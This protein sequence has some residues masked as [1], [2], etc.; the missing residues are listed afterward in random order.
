M[1]VYPYQP[2][3]IVGQTF[4]LCVQPNK[5]F[6]IKI[7]YQGQEEALT[8]ISEDS[9]KILSIDGVIK[10][11]RGKNGRAIYVS[12]NRVSEQ[13]FDT[14]WQWPSITFLTNRDV[15]QTNAY[16]AVVFE[17][18]NDGVG[19]DTLGQK[20]DRGEAILPYPPDSD[21]MALLVGKPYNPATTNI[22][23]IIPTATYQVYNWTGGG[24]FYENKYE[25]A[26]GKTVVTTR[27][28]GG[29]LGTS[30]TNLGE[31]DDAY[32]KRS[33]RQ[34]FV[35]WDAKFIRWMKSENITC[36]F[37]CD[38]DFHTGSPAF[39]LNLYP[40]II[41]VGH[42]EYWSEQMRYNLD[43]F[44]KQGGNYACFSGNTCYRPIGFGQYRTP[45]F[46][47]QIDRLGDNWG[48]E[49]NESKLLG[50]SYTYGGGRW[51]D[52]SPE[53][54][55]WIN[56]ERGNY[57]YTV[58]DGKETHWIFEGTGLTKGA[59]F[60][61]GAN[62]FLVGY[63]VDGI[64]P[65]DTSFNV[66]AK[67]P[68]LKN[69]D[70]VWDVEGTGCLGLLGEDPDSEYKTGIVFNGGTTDWARVLTDETAASNKILKQI[71]KN[72]LSKLSVRFDQ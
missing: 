65:G 71:T 40:L 44:L 50:L 3:F 67:S 48:E 59:K 62:D 58:L 42:H 36:D 20:I 17:V 37:Y 57:G 12:T 1:Q 13:R 64:P 29:G 14:D 16:V 38:Q 51:G 31:P 21:S 66:L 25:G 2:S 27:R 52:W 10:K 60:G 43:I 22:A 45:Q 28:P 34:Q 61:G 8:P 49:K 41:S 26:A 5:Q 18:D 9:Y 19:T 72:V 39:N 54:H 68:E 23:Y 7:F 32:D 47:N 35:H 55:D 11:G 53:A 56:L 30:G 24:R 6:S 69:V 63:E 15:W 70:E 4:T 33:P 46:M